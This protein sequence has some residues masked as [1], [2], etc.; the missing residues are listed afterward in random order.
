MNIQHS[1]DVAVLGGIANRAK[2]RV[3]STAL[4]HVAEAQS[5]GDS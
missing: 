4:R 1:N 3:D 2:V 5:Q